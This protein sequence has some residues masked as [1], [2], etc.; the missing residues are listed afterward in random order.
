MYDGALQRIT[1]FRALL[2]VFL[3][4][5]LSSRRHS[6]ASMSNRLSVAVSLRTLDSAVT[7]R[8]RALFASN[9]SLLAFMTLESSF[10]ELITPPCAPSDQERP[11]SEYRVHQT[12]VIPLTLQRAMAYYALRALLTT[13]DYCLRLQLSS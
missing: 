6:P 1:E 2:P 8:S 5:G 12:R 3:R 11:I 10:P 13:G 4:H 9:V 7:G